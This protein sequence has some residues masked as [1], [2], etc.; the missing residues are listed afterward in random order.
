MKYRTHH[1]NELS[2][3]HVGKCVRLAGWVHRFRNHG[4][5]VFIDL[6]DRFGIT[7]IVCREKDD[8]ELHQRLNAVRSEWVLAVEGKVCSRLSGMENPNISTGD[9]EVEIQKLQI[10][11]KSQNLPF[12]ISDEHIQVNE[13]LR[14]QYRYLDM[15]RGEILDRLTCRHNVMLACRSFLSELGFIEVVTPILGKSTPEGARDYVVPSRIY[16]GE[17]YALPQS[18]Q[19]F[20][21]LLMVG[22]L[23]RYFQIATCF[24]DED[25][26][27]DRQPEFAQIDIEMSFGDTQDLFPII[28]KLVASI[29][30]VKG[31]EISLPLLKMT[32]KDAMDFYGTDKPD[33]RFD[34]RL[35][36]CR[37][38]AKNFSFS[39]FLDQLA[40]GGTIK[41]FCVSGGADISRKQLDSY[42]EFVKRYG[43]M[44]LVWIKKQESGVSSNVSKFASEEAFEAMFD[45]F[46]AQN[47][48]I[49]LLIAAPESV[50]NQALDHL[51]R[52]IAKE[53]QLYDENQ[54]NFV[55]ITDFPLF[56]LTEG[57]LS[58]E[59]HPFTAPLEEDIS[60][61]D[62]KPLSVRSS[63]YDLVLNG[64]EIASGS[65]RIH[66]AELQNKIFAL[67]KLSPQSIEEKFGFFIKA[68]SFGTPPHLGIALGLDRLIMVLTQTESIREVIAF[69]KTQKAADLMMN[70]PAEIMSSQLKELNIKVAS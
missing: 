41:G 45:D 10:L 7:Q 48:D 55:W 46:G 49:L 5:V 59:H 35:K 32:Y 56:T 69:P 29:F 13:E 68:L 19:I 37:N 60:L 28:E 1:C 51:R 21:Q 43:A 61:L 12:S 57:E 40:Q 14:L 23:D 22:G 42:T 64:Y 70:A 36:D 65:Q 4:G 39:I 31:I 11:S 6:R 66:S 44:G 54:F 20:K 47:Q 8:Q 38:H 67:L 3:N 63:S 30:A 34:L 26:R 18:P 9:I 27:A 24:R 33:L 25:L 53:R 50:A 2:I 62:S 52:L 58:A 15:R 17:F 16:P